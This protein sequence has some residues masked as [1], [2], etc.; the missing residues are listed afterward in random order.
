MPSTWN[1]LKISRDRF[2][3]LKDVNHNCI[4][5]KN[6]DDSSLCIKSG[7]RWNKYKVSLTFWSEDFDWLDMD[8]EW[9]NKGSEWRAW[10]RPFSNIQQKSGGVVLKEINKKDPPPPPGHCHLAKMTGI[11]PFL[12]SFKLRVGYRVKLQSK[13]AAN[14]MKRNLLKFPV[15]G[16]PVRR[17]GSSYIRKQIRWSSQEQRTAGCPPWL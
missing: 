8:T 3:D 7:N 11:K 2:K 16:L 9:K 13:E 15:D 12:I 4:L 5:L 14:Q 10:V 6:K 17:Q 1:F